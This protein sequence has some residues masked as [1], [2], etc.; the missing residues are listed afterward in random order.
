[1]QRH[2]SSHTYINRT[3]FTPIFNVHFTPLLDA[4]SYVTVPCCAYPAVLLFFFTLTAHIFLRT[5]PAV[6]TCCAIIFLRTYPAAPYYF[7]FTYP[8]ITLI[9]Y[10]LTLL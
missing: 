2:T 1:M 9:F 6:L 3:I 10:A 5:Y 8:A 4:V 7:I